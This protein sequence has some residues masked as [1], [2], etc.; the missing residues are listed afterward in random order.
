[1]LPTLRL[2]RDRGTLIS[3]DGKYLSRLS[4]SQETLPPA[5]TPLPPFEANL[6]FPLSPV[7]SPRAAGLFILLMV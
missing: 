3:P 2:P 1:M 7:V 5:A 4:R 6:V